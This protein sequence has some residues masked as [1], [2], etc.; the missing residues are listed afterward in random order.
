MKLFHSATLT[1]AALVAAAG[2]VNAHGGPE[3][4][5]EL[6]EFMSRQESAYHC[7]PAVA[8][9]T[10]ARKRSWA[11]RVLGGDAL[12]HKNL[13]VDGYFQEQMG[14]EGRAE[15]LEAVGKQLMECNPVQ[16]SKIRNSTCVLAPEVTEG[17]YYHIKGHPIRSNLAEYQIGL[18]FLMNVGVI[19]VNTCEPVPNVLVD[20]WHANATGSYGG[21]PDPRP[22]LVNEQPAADG[23]RKGLLSAYPRTKDD[24]TWLR[25]ALPTDANGVAEFTSIF[26]GY[27]TGRATHVHVKVHPDWTQLPNGTFISS[28]VLHTGQL[29]VEDRLNEEIDKI[30]PY[31]ENPIRTLPGRGRTRNW[32]DSLQV[33]QE[34]QAN[35]YQP[36]FDIE[37]LG[38]VVTQGLIGYIT[39]GINMSAPGYVGKW[40]PES[41]KAGSL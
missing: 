29:F 27:Y 23:V 20:L 14:I 28:K 30:W 8:A 7:A 15:S 18:L 33:Y 32:D 22:D 17:P 38:G 37:L 6:Q 13:F 5:G 1:A 36:T 40:N 24:E 9:Y 31:S 21:H 2:C 12:A 34:A 10:A 39:L 35:G 25:G 16:A 3:T 41:G 26:P 4:K 19:D 11:Q